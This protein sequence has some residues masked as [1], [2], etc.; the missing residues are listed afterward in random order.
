MGGYDLYGTYYP[1]VNDALNAEMIQCNE[2][3]N[4]INQEK[5]KKFERQKISDEEEIICL[6]EKIRMLED[7]IIRL[8]PK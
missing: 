3:D 5:I 4:R 8:E 6:W 2:I 1:N 7:R